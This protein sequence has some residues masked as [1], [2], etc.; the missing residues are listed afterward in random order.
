MT[1]G[2][3]FL[4]VFILIYLSDCLIW[5]PPSGYAVLAF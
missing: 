5:L 4:L 2:Q 1:D 3:T